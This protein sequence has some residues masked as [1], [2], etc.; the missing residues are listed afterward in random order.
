M[1]ATYIFF[2]KEVVSN[3]HGARALIAIQDTKGYLDYDFMLKTASF[4]P[5]A[6]YMNTEDRWTELLTSMFPRYNSHSFQPSRELVQCSNCGPKHSLWTEVLAA[7]RIVV[8]YR[9]GSWRHKSMKEE[10]NRCRLIKL[11]KIWQRSSVE[12]PLSPPADSE[13]RFLGD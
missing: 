5:T 7:V 1:S 9:S 6:N 3:F 4:T 8:H 13:N 2:D 12:H 11:D 10:L